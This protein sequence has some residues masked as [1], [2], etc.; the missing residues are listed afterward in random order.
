MV[1]KLTKLADGVGR[2]RHQNTNLGKIPPLSARNGAVL[3][4]AGQNCTNRRDSPSYLSKPESVDKFTYEVTHLEDSLTYGK[5]WTSSESPRSS[6]LRMSCSG[7][8]DSKR[9]D[10]GGSVSLLL[11]YT[12]RSTIPVPFFRSPY[13]NA[14]AVHGIS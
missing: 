10:E 5:Y 2:S 14:T 8:V 3:L 7:M 4:K 13:R 6:L 11:R 9:I 12:T 1:I